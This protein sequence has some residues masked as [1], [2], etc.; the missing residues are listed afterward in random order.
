MEINE[1]QA[2]YFFLL[3]SSRALR[4]MQRS[5]RLAHI[6]RLLCRPPEFLHK[7][8]VNIVFYSLGTTVMQNFGGVNNA[9]YGQCENGE[10]KIE[11]K[12]T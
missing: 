5:P 12:G 2:L 7:H 10:F 3:S 4:K 11:S 9:L 8:R 1:R 6:K